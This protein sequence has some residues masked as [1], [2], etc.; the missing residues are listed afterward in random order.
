MGRSFCFT[1]EDLSKKVLTPTLRHSLRS[2][3]RN[4]F[5]NPII[6]FT[7][8]NRRLLSKLALQV[9]ISSIMGGGE[10]HEDST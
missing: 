6:R 9:L 2:Y 5:G 7:A 10:N 4:P 8:Q 1:G 3:Y